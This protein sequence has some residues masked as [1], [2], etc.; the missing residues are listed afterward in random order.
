[1]LASLVPAG[2]LMMNMFMGHRA[3]TALDCQLIVK[4]TLLL[5]QFSPSWY[6][7]NL[8]SHCNRVAVE[9]EEFE[10]LYSWGLHVDY[11]LIHSTVCILI[12]F[13]KTKVFWRLNPEPTISLPT[14]WAC[15]NLVTTLN[16]LHSCTWMRSCTLCMTCDVGTQC[17]SNGIPYFVAWWT[18]AVHAL[19]YQS[20]YISWQRRPLIGELLNWKQIL[21]SFVSVMVLQHYQAR[22]HALCEYN[23]AIAA[24]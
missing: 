3:G 19:M 18:T 23:S 15:P 7:I 21:F 13:L 14:F 10:L 4:R 6:Q 1:M 24:Y 20:C 12:L 9:F 16:T 8:E 11:S 17:T 5:T 2:W 22:G